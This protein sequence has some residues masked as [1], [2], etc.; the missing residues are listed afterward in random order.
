VTPKPLTLLAVGS[1]GIAALAAGCGNASSSNPLGDGTSA[2]GTTP[3]ATFGNTDDDAGGAG[4]GGSSSFGG[5]SSSGSGSSTMGCDPTCA[6]AGGSCSGSSCTLVENPGK[7]IATTQAALQ[8]K[9]S[10]D[11]SFQWLYPYDGT[12]FARGL[13]APTL[14]LASASAD[15]EY[16]HVTSKNLDYSGYF[17]AGAQQGLNLPLPQRSWDAITHAV[18]AADVLK[19]SVSK[20]SGTTV[21]GP[22]SE[23]WTIAQGS[24]RGTIYYETYDS[25]ILGGGGSDAGG[26]SAILGSVLSEAGGI[27]IMKIQ[28]GATQPTPLKTGCGN[29]CHAAS[30]DGSTLV[31]ATTIA[32]SASYDLKTSASTLFAP[33]NTDF[34][35]GGLYPDGSFLMSATDFRASGNTASQLLD[36][37]TGAV[38]AAPGWDGVV[39]RGGT[40]A[41]SPDGKQ[42]AFVHEDKD[43]HTLAKMDFDVGRKTFSNLVDLAN[44]PGGYIGW[45]AFTPDGKSVV[46]HSGS[47]Q[48]FETDLGASGD[49]FIVDIATKT[50]HRLDRLDGYTASG[51]YLPA[52]DPKLNFA[53]TVLPEAV[54]GY[55]WAVFTSHRSYGNLSPSMANADQDGKLWVSAIDIGAAPGTDASH[56]AFYLDGQELTADNL[57]GFWVLP[58]CEQNGGSCAS[59]DQCCSGFCRGSGSAQACVMKPGG[60]SN[61]YESCTTSADCCNTGD[62]CINGRCAGV[63][64]K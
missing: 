7:V 18:G 32:T 57:R 14:Q 1:L 13:V 15:A 31:A 62:Q 53:P 58:P 29:V 22:V 27:G 9:G 61:D 63:T 43:G 44:D 50:A 24:L 51:N 20:V 26:L 59:G 54:G 23:S 25:T 35:Y 34:T 56:P 39:T 47:N 55:F 28:P 52:N 17:A 12:V 10:T 3:S 40:T 21:T 37:K 49:V 8:G 36:V 42:I 48:S 16:V 45:P 5:G 2:P 11:A 19:V 46:Y 4:S 38:I 33:T 64:P 41:F 60:C 6:A 30:A